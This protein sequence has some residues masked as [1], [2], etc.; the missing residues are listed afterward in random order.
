MIIKIIKKGK[1]G[2]HMKKIIILLRIALTIC[3][4]AIHSL[5]SG[6]Y[7][8]SGYGSYYGGYYKNYYDE[9]CSDRHRDA[10]VVMIEIVVIG[11]MV[12]EIMGNMKGET[13]MMDI[14]NNVVENYH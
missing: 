3:A 14:E 9:Y 2:D 1:K 8:T 5:Y 11:D 6:D 13:M 7:E 12:V 4:C 10:R